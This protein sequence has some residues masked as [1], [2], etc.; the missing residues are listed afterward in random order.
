MFGFDHGEP[1][2]E[3]R[4]GNG[5]GYEIRVTRCQGNEDSLYDCELSEVDYCDEVKRAGVICSYAGTSL[6]Q[7]YIS[8]SFVK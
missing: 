1:T 5:Y 7:I 8:I 6:K 2:E 3:L 4:Y